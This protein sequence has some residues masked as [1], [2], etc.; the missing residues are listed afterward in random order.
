VVRVQ[1]NERRWLESSGLQ[2]VQ[3][4]AHVIVGVA[5]RCVV[6]SAHVA[7][8]DRAERMVRV[9]WILCSDSATML[10]LQVCRIGT[11]GL[12]VQRGGHVGE[13]VSGVEGGGC[14]EGRVRLLEADL[15][16]VGIGARG[17][18]GRERVRVEGAGLGFG[19]KDSSR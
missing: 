8:I 1:H 13:R 15:A 16:R 11:G 5:E 18:P 10:P 3:Q 14:I 19:L 12:A 7:S 17:G 9:V 4:S 6:S 2:G